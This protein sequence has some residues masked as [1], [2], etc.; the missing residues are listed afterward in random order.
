[1][2]TLSVI[3][4]VNITVSTILKY[5][6]KKASNK[7]LKLMGEAMK[8]FPKKLLGHEIFGSMVSW[9]TDFFFEKFVKPS[10]PLLYS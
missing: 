8:Y 2:L 4:N 3:S 9:A 6:C 5:C 7:K 1:M 10:A